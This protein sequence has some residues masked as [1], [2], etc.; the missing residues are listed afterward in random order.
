MSQKAN[1]ND[2]LLNRDILKVAII[3][4]HEP[5]E[6]ISDNNIAGLD[7]D[8]INMIA[9]E[10]NLKVEFYITTLDKVFKDV[11]KGEECDVAI[12]D[13]QITEERQKFVFMSNSYYSTKK[14]GKEEN[15]GIAIGKDKI[16]LY[17]SINNVIDIKKNN[18][19]I[20]TIINK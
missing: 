16:A 15:A 2:E 9:K 18:G 13:L 8:I 14:D 10:L 6:Y 3:P 20:D 1:Y 5:F 11:E 12:S 17:R 19:E 4:D 7:V